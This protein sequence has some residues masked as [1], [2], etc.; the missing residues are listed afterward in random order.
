MAHSAENLDVAS[1]TKNTAHSWINANTP[2]GSGVKLERRLMHLFYQGQ[3]IK[4][5]GYNLR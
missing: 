1:N 2:S 5:W 4:P 3:K